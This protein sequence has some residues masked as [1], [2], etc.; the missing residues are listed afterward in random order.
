MRGKK[1]L[2]GVEFGDMMEVLFEPAPIEGRA[3]TLAQ[4]QE[5]L[6]QIT[7]LPPSEFQALKK[8]PNIDRALPR[9]V[10]AVVLTEAFGYS[11]LDLT[12]RELGTGLIIEAGIRTATRN[13]N[14]PL[15][16]WTSKEVSAPLTY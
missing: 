8:K 4:L 11:Q 3:L 12:E 16:W 2:V 14:V 7:S 13:R 5:K 6:S 1:T 15:N 10:V 9:L